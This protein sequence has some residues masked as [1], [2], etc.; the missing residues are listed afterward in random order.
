VAVQGRPKKVRYI[1]SMPKIVQFSPR[2]KPGRPEEIE[3]SIDQFEALKLADFQGFSQSEGALAMQ[4]SRPSFGRLLREARRSIADALVNGK[5]IKIRQGDVQIGVRKVELS[6]QTLQ[7]ELSK[8][9]QRNKR[10]LKEI[11]RAA[12]LG[13]LARAK[14]SQSGL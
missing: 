13:D 11:R 4:L 14:E 1:Q 2:G 9:K 8:F 12:N 10:V 7:D 3:L 6:S 5:I